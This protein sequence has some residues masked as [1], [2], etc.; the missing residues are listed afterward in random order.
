MAAPQSE[1]T[2]TDGAGEAYSIRSVR[3]DEDSMAWR[4]GHMPV[5]RVVPRKHAADRQHHDMRALPL[6][7]AARIGHPARLEQAD[8]EGPAFEQC[9]AD[10][11][12]DPFP[13]SH[14]AAGYGAPGDVNVKAHFPITSVKVFD[15][16]SYL[17]VLKN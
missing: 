6:D 11:V 16:F 8:L 9:P 7:I 13:A 2:V 17:V 10:D 5:R 15:G 4:T 14:E 1:G 3:G 12:H